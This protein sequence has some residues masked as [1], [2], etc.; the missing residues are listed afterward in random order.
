MIYVILAHE[1]PKALQRLV[2]KLEDKNAHFIVHIDKACD[3]VPFK[4]SLNDT[5]NCHFTPERYATQWGSI[6]LVEAV[7]HSFDYIRKRLRKR[8]RIVLLSGSDYPI[9]NKKYITEY[10][11]SHKNTLFLEYNLIPRK[12]W[13]NGGI[14]RFPL[15]HE[16]KEYMKLYGGAQWFSIPAKA[17]T[18]VFQF[19][20][21]NPDFLEYFRQVAIPDESFFQ[22]LFL[23]CNHPFII[24]NLRNQNLHFIKWDKPY[25]HP[26]VMTIKDYR[27]IKKSKSLFARKFNPTRSRELLLRLDE[28][29]GSS[30]E[31]KKNRTAV[32]F[33]TEKDPKE[34]KNKYIKLK[35]EVKQASVF[36]IVTRNEI[37]KRSDDTLLYEHRYFKQLGYIPFVEHSIIPGSTYF[38]LLYFWTLYPDYD[39]YWLIEDD[40]LYN[41]DWN[42]FFER[43]KDNDA[44]LVSTYF[45]SYQ[46]V[47]HWHWWKALT[48]EKEVPYDHRRRTFYPICRFSAQALSY[49]DQRLKRGDHGHGEVL[50]PTL[51]Y[52]H[53]FSFHEIGSPED[54]TIIPST[55]KAVGNNNT[56]SF[57]YRPIIKQNE[58]KGEYL[59][60]PVKEDH[61]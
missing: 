55:D 52:L 29:S 6:A 34:I 21:L 32:L 40:V 57:R 61:F 13:Y 27:Q 11:R 20:K 38:A 2:K 39:Y 54:A 46:E 59:F 3:I 26:R 42:S 31:V 37:C 12:I 58:I 44:D 17:V 16:V 30:G 45:S 15:Y 43:F 35:Q 28:D 23:N 9:Q 33:L 25:D 41:G 8:Q 24:K 4:E 47:P 36:R 48:T 10:L 22:T 51:L 18:I 7:L 19:L 49:L 60:H 56:G 5:K 50:V 14:G 1:A 53:G